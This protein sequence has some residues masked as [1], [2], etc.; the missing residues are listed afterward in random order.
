MRIIGGRWRGHAL[1]APPGTT[2][3]PTGIRLRQ[4]IFD[5]LAHAPWAGTTWLAGATVLDMFAGT[6]A[7]GLE[8]LSRG[9][10]SAEFYETDPAAWQALARNI[11]ACGAGGMAI[12]RRDALTPARGTAAALVFLDPPYFQDL[13]AQCVMAL[14]R[15]GRLT[16]ATILVSETAREEA[17]LAGECLA[18]RAHGAGRVRFM[19][20]G[21]M[22]GVGST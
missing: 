4:A 2:T 17:P 21:A 8:A 7:M 1:V 16:P 19:K 18:E 5:M 6:G 20:A 12:A 15:A 3:R 11:T 22:A 13:V 10:A 9:A 14:G